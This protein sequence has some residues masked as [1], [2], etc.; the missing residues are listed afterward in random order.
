MIH[1]REMGE[2]FGIAMME[3]L[4]FN[5]PV[6]A[7]EKGNDLNHV[8]ILKPFDLL[9]NSDNIE[10]KINELV[11]RKSYDFSSVVAEY[12]P[13]NVMNKFNEVFLYGIK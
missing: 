10:Q 8:D 5:K 12:T 6:L 2:T 7:W 4:Q 1:A 9:Y 3:F 13:A 11:S